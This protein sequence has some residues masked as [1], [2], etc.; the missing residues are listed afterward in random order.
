MV[1]AR[2]PKPSRSGSIPER[3]AERVRSRQWLNPGAPSETLGDVL[4]ARIRSLRGLGLVDGEHEEEA[5][6]Q[7]GESPGD[8]AFAATRGSRRRFHKP[9]GV[10]F[11]SARRDEDFEVW[12][13]GIARG[14]GPRDRRFNSSHLD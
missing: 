1:S 11:K 4:T 9:L 7:L 6:A 5:K 13:S 2:S 8:H 14:S 12:R 10:R 3:P